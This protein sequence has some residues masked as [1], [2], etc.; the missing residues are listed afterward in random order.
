MKAWSYFKATK[1]GEPSGTR[2]GEYRAFPC[3][4]ELKLGEFSMGYEI[5]GPAYLSECDGNDVRE[6]IDFTLFIVNVSDR[7][8]CS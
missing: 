5:V 7:K 4:L 3:Q 1:P 8:C 6:C 2:V